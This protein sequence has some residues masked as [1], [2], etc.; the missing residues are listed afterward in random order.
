VYPRFPTPYP[1]GGGALA[2]CEVRLGEANKRARSVIGLT[3]DGLAAKTR[4]EMPPASGDGG[5]VAAR[6]QKLGFRREEERSSTMC[7]TVASM[8]PR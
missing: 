7:S 1:D 2:G 4:P 8:C 5:A 6:P 3:R